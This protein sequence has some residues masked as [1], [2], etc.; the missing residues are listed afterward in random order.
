L[1]AAH[2]D[3][4][5]RFLAQPTLLGVAKSFGF[6]LLQPWRLGRSKK[7]VGRKGYTNHRWIVGGKLGFV[8]NRFGLVCA[9][10]CKTANTR[11]SQYP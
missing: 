8:L 2:K 3:W 9:W 10:D 11:N 7:Q 5:D 1:L 4:T 6:K